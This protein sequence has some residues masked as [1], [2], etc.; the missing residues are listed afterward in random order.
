MISIIV[1]CYNESEG[2]PQ[3]RTRLLPVVKELEK[4]DSVELI[5]V[6]DGS[7]DNTNQL[8][9]ENFSGKNVSVVKHEKN[10]NLGAAVRTGLLAANGDTIVTMDSDC[11]YAPENIPNMIAQLKDCDIVTA[12]PYHP[13]GKVVGVPEY[14]LFLSRGVT[15]IYNVVSGR[16]LYTWTALFR[17]YKRDAISGITI[18]NNDFI[19]LVE[20]LVK[21][22]NRGAKIKEV[23]ETLYV[24]KY[25]TSKMRLLRV[26]G[27]HLKFISKLL[28]SSG[29][30]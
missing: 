3:L 17:A 12:S 21:A 10:M 9:R 16:H 23:P 13:A 22:A 18:T 25:G 6:D 8:L 5:F 19:A 2:I 29:V 30:V 24:R 4:S 1:P 20:L 11:T 7:I 26:I 27:N 15:L 14:R 28:F